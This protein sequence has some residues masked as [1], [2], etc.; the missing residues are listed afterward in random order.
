MIKDLYPPNYVNDIRNIL[1][2]QIYRIT[3]LK[4][5]SVD[6]PFIE[7]ISKDKGFDVKQ[8]FLSD[9]K[10][11]TLY[12]IFKRRIDLNLS[13]SRIV[14]LPDDKDYNEVIDI[15]RVQSIENILLR[16][17]AIEFERIN[18]EEGDVYDHNRRWHT[19]RCVDC[20]K[21]FFFLNDHSK[22]NGTYEYSQGS[23]QM[24][25]LRYFYEYYVS[26]RYSLSQ[27]LRG[28]LETYSIFL[29]KFMAEIVHKKIVMEYPKNTLIISN[30]KGFHRRGR[31]SPNTVREQVNFDFYYN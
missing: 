13:E 17:P 7:H 12:E 19:D 16:K 31:L 29:S 2:Y 22:E 10:L 26:L 20:Y 25:L 1:G 21:M 27:L 5:L 14:L 9:E 11:Q 18:I 8:N 6:K 3:K 30:N 4:S 28:R 24:S 23:S 15:F